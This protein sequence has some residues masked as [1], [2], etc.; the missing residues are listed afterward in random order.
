MKRILGKTC[1]VTGASLGIGRACALRLAEEGG[2]VALFDVL[3]DDG[4]A[5]RDELRASGHDA[6]YWHVDVS[7]EASVRAA[8]D[9]VAAHFGSVDVLVNNAGI[10]ASTSHH[11]VSEA[12]W[13][14]CRDVN[15]KGVFFCTKM[16]L[17]MPAPVPAASS[18][19][20][21]LGLVARRTCRPTCVQ[22]RGHADGQ[23]DACSMRRTASASIRCTRASSGRHWWPISSS[24]AGRPTSTSRARNSASCMHWAMSASPTTSPGAW[25]TW[26][27]TKRS[28]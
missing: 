12:E 14:A 27:R 7:S 17:P 21:H 28:S 23:D 8:V 10:A 13:T 9:E 18:P 3:D 20:V 1:I 15:V 6:E 2:R 19:V 26:P 24:P 11:E 16:C 25:S 4:S 5:L 22:G